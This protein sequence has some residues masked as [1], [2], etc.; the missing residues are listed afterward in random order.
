MRK[1]YVGL[2]VSLAVATGVLL[3]GV[4]YAGEMHGKRGR[5]GQGEGGKCMVTGKLMMLEHNKKKLGLTDEQAG[6]IASI[7]DGLTKDR[8]AL[9]AQIDTLE[10]DIRTLV[11]ADTI[12]VDKV[13][14]LIEKKYEIEKEIGLKSIEA[15]ASA[16]KVLTPEQNKK[17]REMGRDM[18]KSHGP[19]GK[20]GHHRGPDQGGDEKGERK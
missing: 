3:H 15:L 9:N 14:P 19:K 12:E 1:G 8:I 6:K 17:A 4:L 7:K 16:Q 13:R 2:A 20:G 11:T 18:W 10:V 5:C